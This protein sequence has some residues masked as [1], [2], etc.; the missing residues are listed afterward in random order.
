MHVGYE[1]TAL[2]EHRFWLQVLGDHARFIYDSLSTSEH[3]EIRRAASFIHVFDQLLERAR[4]PEASQLRSLAVQAKH[5][6]REIRRFKLHLIQRHLVGQIKI[7]LSPTFINHM[8][9]EVEEYLRI[10]HYL[11]EGRIPPPSHPIHHHLVWLLDAAG[12]AG[13]IHDHLDAVEKQLRKKGTEFTRHFEQFYLKAVELAGYL[14]TSLKEFPAL[15][16][17]N[18]Q[19]ELELAFF[20]KFLCELEEMRMDN[21]ALGVLSPLMADHMAREECYYLI[22]LAESTGVKRPD[23]DP[24]KPRMTGM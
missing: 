7:S 2:Y 21:E 12:H 16:R 18:H 5:H 4:H 8:V 23:C 13:A 19:V 17:F 22:K 9:N 1:D 6:A 3:A 20:R 10:L 14:R 24:A 11:V 15:Q